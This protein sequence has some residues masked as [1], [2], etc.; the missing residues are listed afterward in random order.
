M[1]KHAKISTAA[2]TLY[3]L[4]KI[5]PIVL[6]F[7]FVMPHGGDSADTASVFADDLEPDIV[8]AA[9]ARL[10]DEFDV[11]C[12][13]NGEDR[14]CTSWNVLTDEADA[15]AL[16]LRRRRDEQDRLLVSSTPDHLFLVGAHRLNRVHARIEQ[17]WGP[18][19]KPDVAKPP[20]TKIR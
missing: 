12:R 16:I 3:A 18:M 11:S 13:R 8:E 6:L 2:V 17:L 15:S 14:R 20:E 5:V 19:L 9:I 1:S 4:Y 7:V 10:E